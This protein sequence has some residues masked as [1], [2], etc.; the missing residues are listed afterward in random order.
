MRTRIV[1]ARICVILLL[2]PLSFDLWFVA[3]DVRNSSLVSK[4]ECKPT[5][6]EAD[7]D[8][9]G[10][11]G[12][13]I[14]DRTTPLPPRIPG[15]PENFAWI[16]VI[17]HQTELMRFPY[18]H[19]DSTLRTHVAIHSESG[20]ARLLIYD[21]INPEGAPPT[22]VFAWDGGRMGA[23]NASKAD[24]RILE[25]MAARDDT[26]SWND[27]VDFRLLHLPLVLFY[28]VPLI[29]VMIWIKRHTNIT[30]GNERK[31]LRVRSAL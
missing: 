29:G 20:R 21:R 8:G 4:Y 1:A 9:D 10:A 2:F 18:R 24:Q 6:C 5:E 12:S 3:K 26:G 25:A 28:Y 13:V 7:F 27:W 11:L 23:V 14:F 17:E 30:P 19:V 15:T 31:P 16:V 22:G